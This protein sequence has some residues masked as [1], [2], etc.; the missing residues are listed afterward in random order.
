MSFDSFESI[1]SAFGRSFQLK[2]FILC[3]FFMLL[4]GCVVTLYAVS[5]VQNEAINSLGSSAS[6]YA[7]GIA[8]RITD[9]LDSPLEISRTT[10]KMFEGIKLRNIPLSRQDTINMLIPVFSSSPYLYGG[11]TCWEPNEFDGRDV[12]Y[13]N[14]MYHDETGRFVPYVHKTDGGDVYV[15][16]ATGYTTDAWYLGAQTTGS[17]VITEPFF[18]NISGKKELMT[19]IS[20][21]IIVDE[22]FLG[23]VMVDVK[24]GRIQEHADA[25]KKRMGVGEMLVASNTGHI[26]AA[27]RRPELQNQP[28]AAFHSFL[29]NELINTEY[30]KSGYRVRDGYIEVYAPIYVSGTK[31]PWLVEVFYPT[32]VILKAV[33][34]VIIKLAIM[35]LVATILGVMCIWYGVRRLMYP[36]QMTAIGL[37]ELTAGKTARK[38][39]PTGN[40]EIAEICRSFDKLMDRIEA[41]SSERFTSYS[42]TSSSLANSLIKVPADVNN[43]QIQPIVSEMKQHIADIEQATVALSK[44]MLDLSG[45]NN[46]YFV[47]SSHVNEYYGT[48]QRVADEIGTHVHELQKVVFA[49][50]KN[51][52]HVEA[53]SDLIDIEDRLY[54]ILKA[55]APLQKK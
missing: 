21:P 6:D 8:N 17:S 28:M 19:T 22:T 52:S 32:D 39:N 18:A 36:L 27:T 41:Q 54:L 51:Y 25:V 50:K 48:V 30:G 9:E 37:S 45:S 16:P 1:Q 7:S 12:I 23:T 44:S 13:E 29:S 3:G 11:G 42:D 15:L 24:L 4:A 31:T 40:D 35:G 2:I 38:I 43:A 33:R 49:M 53:Q 26:I 55:L 34:P 47:S 14:S 10:A 5:V 20:S 46:S